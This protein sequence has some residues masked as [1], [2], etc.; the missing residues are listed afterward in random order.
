MSKDWFDK[1]VIVMTLDDD[2]KKEKKIKSAI[3]KAIVKKFSK[4]KRKVV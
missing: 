2:K 1:H 4:T 3:K